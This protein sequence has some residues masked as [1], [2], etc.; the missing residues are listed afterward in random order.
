M[1]TLEDLT[2]VIN[3]LLTLGAVLGAMCGGI[4]WAIK[5]CVERLLMDIKNEIA[6]IKNIISNHTA[7]HEEHSDKISKLIEKTSEHEVRLLFVENSN[8]KGSKTSAKI[9]SK[10]SS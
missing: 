6:G 10:I 5:I 1:A 2:T 4:L 8:V 3:L 7:I 9:R